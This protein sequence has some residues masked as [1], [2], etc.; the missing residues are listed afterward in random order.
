M[1]LVHPISAFNYWLLAG[2]FLPFVAAFGKQP[3]ITFFVSS[4]TF[5]EDSAFASVKTTK[6]YL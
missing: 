2:F 1:G 5:L 6:V 3:S 4:C